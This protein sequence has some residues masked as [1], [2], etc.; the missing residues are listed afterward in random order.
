MTMLTEPSE[1]TA[2]KLP[3]VSIDDLIV[4]KKSEQQLLKERL[5]DALAKLGGQSTAEEDILFQGTKLILPEKMTLSEAINFLEEKKVEDGRTVSY[6]RTFQYR[7]WD[8]ARATMSALKKA[9]GAVSQRTTQ[10]FWGEQPPRLVTI[11]VSPT[12]TEQ[13]PWGALG[14]I[15]LSKTTLYL[16]STQDAEYGEIFQINVEGPRRYRHHIEGI[17]R[18]VQEELET[19]SLYRGKAFDG[20]KMPQFL[21]LSGV[22]PRKVIYSEETLAQ[23]DANIWSVLRYPDALQELGV[24]LKRAVL[25]EGPYGTGKTLAAFL[26]AQIAVANGWSFLLCRPGQDNLLDVMST[27]RLYQP[28]VVFFE[29]VDIVSEATADHIPRLLDILDG[30]KAKGLRLMCV[31]T[32]NHAERIHKAMVR[33]GRLDAVI[34]VGALDAKGIRKLVEATVPKDL[35]SIPDDE[36]WERIALSMDGFMPAFAR[37]AIDRAVRYNVAR[38]EGHATKLEGYD[39]VHAANGL[40]PQLELMEGAK[41]RVDADPL[42][43]VMVDL[44]ERAIDGTGIVN[45]SDDETDYRLNISA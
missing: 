18:L 24:P 31:L 2:T 38:N 34:H 37:E 32:T 23:L 13:V 45:Q 40:R 9:F 3:T 17:F 26:T 42:S 44:M 4:T 12:E 14:V 6:S 29:D 27:A 39:F 20:Q 19:N 41:D 21:D 22:D 25:L 8:G 33:P 35:L 36:W 11:P 1:P 30:L 5:L 7:P 43:Q 16:G 15:H 28:A 10:T